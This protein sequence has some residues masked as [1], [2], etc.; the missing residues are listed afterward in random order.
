MCVCFFL[1]EK[2]T[3]P[4]SKLLL[5]E[6]DSFWDSVEERFSIRVRVGVSV[7][8]EWTVRKITSDW[9][10]LPHSAGNKITVTQSHFLMS[11][12][13]VYLISPLC[14]T[15]HWMSSKQWWLVER[16]MDFTTLFFQVLSSSHLPKIHSSLGVLLKQR[17]FLSLDY[18]ILEILVFSM[19]LF[20]SLFLS[21]IKKQISR[22]FWKYQ[23][24]YASIGS[25]KFEI[26]P[27]ILT[28]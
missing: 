21:E 25:C 7:S 3:L 2:S 14:T 15:P 9:L 8:V 23:L 13:W 16:T 28:L 5:S 22:T 19:P 18:V 17:I 27:R 24:N 11:L 6:I 10:T 1:R 26:S 4:Q 20:R 12:R